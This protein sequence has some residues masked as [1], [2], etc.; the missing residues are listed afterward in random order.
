MLTSPPPS[1]NGVLR[2]GRKLVTSQMSLEPHQRAQAAH[3]SLEHCTHLDHNL[4]T[5]PCLHQRRTQHAF[6]GR[7][8]CA[9]LC[10]RH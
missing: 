6:A 9:K 8:L 3:P 4:P 5:C 1:Y 10:A 2:E 7:W